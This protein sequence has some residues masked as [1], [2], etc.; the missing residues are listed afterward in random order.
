[1]SGEDVEEGV[2]ELV[3]L[4][5]FVCGSGFYEEA[6]GVLG[7]EGEICVE[8][9]SSGPAGGVALGV[10]GFWCCDVRGENCGT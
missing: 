9:D 4:F 8:V 10:C 6:L 2:I 7:A 5:K 3:A 1:M